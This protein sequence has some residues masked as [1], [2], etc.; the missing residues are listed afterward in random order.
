MRNLSGQA[1]PLFVEN[2]HIGIVHGYVRSH[3]P[4]AFAT[5]GKV[6]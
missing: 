4:A 5:Q 1:Y 3:L 6:A 2:R